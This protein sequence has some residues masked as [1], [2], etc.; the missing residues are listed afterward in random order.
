[1]DEFLDIEHLLPPSPS[2]SSDATALPMDEDSAWY[3]PGGFCTI[4]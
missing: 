4:T 2:S 3:R 1:M